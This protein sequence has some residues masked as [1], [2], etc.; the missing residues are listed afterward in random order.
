MGAGDRSM[1]ALVVVEE[2][3]VAEPRAADPPEG[4]ST[5]AV[6]SDAPA[7]AGE[8]DGDVEMDEP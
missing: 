5:S 1:K 4:P 8:G 2:V 7:G 6:V 3:E